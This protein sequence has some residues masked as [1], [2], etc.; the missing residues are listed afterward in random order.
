MKI[1]QYDRVLMKDGC[2]ASIIEIFEEDNFFLSYIDRNGDTY[3]EELSIDEI[4]A[5]I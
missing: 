1:K 2:Q 5:V 3:T 4:K